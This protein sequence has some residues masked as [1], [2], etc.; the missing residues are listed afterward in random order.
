M[1]G[2]GE[3][4]GRPAHREPPPL[5]VGQR[6]RPGKIVQEV[7]VDVQEHP[8]LAQVLDDVVAL[9]TQPGNAAE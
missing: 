1:V 7:A 8:A 9:L 2:Q 6:R 5:D 3:H 4:L